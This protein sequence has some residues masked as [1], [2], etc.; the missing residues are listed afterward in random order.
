[1]WLKDG[2]RAC[3]PLKLFVCSVGWFLTFFC[4][5]FFFCGIFLVF[6]I[7]EMGFIG[8]GRWVQLWLRDGDRACQ[9]SIMF[10]CLVGW[11]LNVIVNNKVIFQA[12]PKTER[13]T[14]LHAV[15]DE[16]ELEDH[17]FC[18]SRSQHTDSDPT[19]RE[20]AARAG[21]EPGTSSPEV[22]RSTP[23]HDVHRN[24]PSHFRNRN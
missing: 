15:T 18:L 14:I 23:F 17:A 11:F 21:M 9:P 16:I 6:L 8:G 4:K 20:R 7:Y 10:V 24:K 22:E 5:S 2:D 13:L 3:Q 1:M 19:S 12:G